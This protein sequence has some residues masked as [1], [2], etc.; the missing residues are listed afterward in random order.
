LL[1]GFFGET[2]LQSGFVQVYGAVY[3]NGIGRIETNPLVADA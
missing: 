1:G 3:N 2:V